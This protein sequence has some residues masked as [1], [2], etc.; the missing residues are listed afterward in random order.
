MILETKNGHIVEIEENI[1]RRI[2]R[3]A[4]EPMNKMRMTIEQVNGETK[5]KFLPIEVN[6]AELENAKIRAMVKSVNKNT[7]NVLEAMLEMKDDDFDQIMEKIN[8]LLGETIE[9]K[10]TF[11]KK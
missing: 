6:Q 5:P 10:K 4:N 8:E 3:Q 7:E 11:K 1:N 2:R 9:A